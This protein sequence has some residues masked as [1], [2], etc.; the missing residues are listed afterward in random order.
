MSVL[1]DSSYHG[2]NEEWKGVF[3]YRPNWTEHHRYLY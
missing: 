3:S 2:L 1:V